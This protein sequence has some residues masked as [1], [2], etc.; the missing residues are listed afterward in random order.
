M[1]RNLTNTPSAV[2]DMLADLDVS[3]ADKAAVR[4][5]LGEVAALAGD[6]PEPSP[7]V[8]ALLGGAL[9]LRRRRRTALVV[10]AAGALALGGVSAAAAANRLPDPIQEIVADATEGVLPV[11]V[12]HPAKPAKPVNPPSDAPGHVRNTPRPTT[13]PSATPPGQIQKST[14]PDP[15]A[16]GPARPADPGSHGRAHNPDRTS[17]APAR[18]FNEPGAAAKPAKVAE[19]GNRVSGGPRPERG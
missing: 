16:P 14:K 7:Q 12:P 18:E 19:S 10:A 11:D 17:S 4:A 2:D 3:D 1:T 5:V 15:Q 13:R 9:P 8:R 6:V